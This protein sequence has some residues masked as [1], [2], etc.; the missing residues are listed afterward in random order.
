MTRGSWVSLPEK[1]DAGFQWRLGRD[2]IFENDPA[3]VMFWSRLPFLL[4]ATLLGYC[5]YAWGRGLFGGTAAVGA[6]ILY[7]LDPTLIA[8]G[9]LVTTDVGFAGFTLLLFYALWTYLNHRTFGKLVL[10]GLAPGAAPA[11]EF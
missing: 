6:L 4:L 8:H 5:L 1:V 3:R 10:C 7:A 9:Q 11:S 2:I